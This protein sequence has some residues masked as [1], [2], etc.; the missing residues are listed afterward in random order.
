MPKL[1]H[2]PASFIWVLAVMFFPLLLSASA[3]LF[4]ISGLIPFI[5]FIKSACFTFCV[6]QI[7]RFMGDAGWLISSLLLFTSTWNMPILF[8]FW[9]RHVHGEKAG[10]CEDLLKCFIFEVLVAAIDT[11]LVAPILSGIVF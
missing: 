2:A 5:A 4:N 6:S 9:F 3:V 7:F 10:V 8:F 1:A 11:I